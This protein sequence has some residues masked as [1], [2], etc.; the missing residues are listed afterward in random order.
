M[1]VP[2]FILN[3]LQEVYN[4]EDC[5]KTYMIKMGL[6]ICYKIN[7]KDVHYLRDD[8]WAYVLYRYLQERIEFRGSIPSIFELSE[9]IEETTLFYCQDPIDIAVEHQRKCCMQRRNLL[10]IA[11]HLANLLRVHLCETDRGNTIDRLDEFALKAADINHSELM[12]N[13]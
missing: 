9:T 7:E 6:F 10:I 2:Q 5:L 3:K 12:M 4:L 13:W 1:P 8:K 11:S